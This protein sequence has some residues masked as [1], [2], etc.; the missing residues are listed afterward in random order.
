[1]L[2]LAYGET[3]TAPSKTRCSSKVQFIKHYQYARQVK[4]LELEEACDS[5]KPGTFK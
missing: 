3:C 1:M 2:A 4:A 5:V